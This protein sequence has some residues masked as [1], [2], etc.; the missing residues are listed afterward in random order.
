MREKNF[1]IGQMILPSNGDFPL[2]EGGVFEKGCQTE[3]VAWNILFKLEG[4]LK[5]DLSSIPF[6][7]S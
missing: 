1:S 4:V 2:L 3:L 7:L 5:A 6:L